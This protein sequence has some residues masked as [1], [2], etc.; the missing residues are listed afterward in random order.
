MDQK[1]A[2]TK[3]IGEKTKL[4]IRKFALPAIVILVFTASAAAGYFYSQSGN[5]KE[6]E[7]A[8]V[9]GSATPPPGAPT[10]FPGAEAAEQDF[11]TVGDQEVG[12]KVTISAVSFLD[13]GYVYIHL[14]GSDGKAGK[15]IGE[16]NLVEG[17]K[18]DLVINLSQNVNSGQALIAMLYDKNKEPLVGNDG[19]AIQQEFKVTDQ[20]K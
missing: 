19:N 8:A 1:D 13:S 6:P 14:A 7:K 15:I 12:N 3:E 9:N 18:V 2:D 10:P 17:I 5:K 20:Q 16:S 11:V 4:G